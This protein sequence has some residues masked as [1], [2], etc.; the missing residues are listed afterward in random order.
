MSDRRK[1]RIYEAPM[2]PVNIWND[3]RRENKGLAEG[4]QKEGKDGDRKLERVMKRGTV[5]SYTGQRMWT[6]IDGRM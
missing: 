5:G 6:S 1:K 2:T 4:I 3:R